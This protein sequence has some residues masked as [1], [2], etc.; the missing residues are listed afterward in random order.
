MLHNLIH[1]HI[2][3]KVELIE[4]ESTVFGGDWK[5]QKER[6]ERLSSVVLHNRVAIVTITHYISQKCEERILNFSSQR[7]DKWGDEYVWS[8]LNIIYVKYYIE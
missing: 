2:S 6:S 8:D 1:R 7:N 3:G 5:D 4:V